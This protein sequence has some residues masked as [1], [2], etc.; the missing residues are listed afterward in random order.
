M[1]RQEDR[2]TVWV[3]ID[4]EEGIVELKL[5]THCRIRTW[6]V[7]LNQLPHI[8]TKTRQYQVI[9]RELVKKC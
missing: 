2:Q 7:Q 5:V 9:H 3:I 6:D 1:T 4:S 8:T